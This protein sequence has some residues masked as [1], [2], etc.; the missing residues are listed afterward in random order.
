MVVW[1]LDLD[2]TLYTDRTGL[3]PAISARI[4]R[5]LEV[6]L[7]LAPGA[8]QALRR[9]WVAAY[10]TTLQ[11]LLHEMPHH[12]DPYD[13][14]AFTHDLPLEAYLAPDP[15]LRRTLEALPGPKWV[16]TN[17]DAAHARRVLEILGVAEVFE[18]IIDI[19]ATDLHP[20]PWE[21]AYRQALTL[22]GNPP[23]GD[24]VLVDD[25]LCNLTAARPLGFRTVWVAREAAAAEARQVD[26]VIPEIYALPRAFPRIAGAPMPSAARGH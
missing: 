6:R 14:F 26:A 10:G 23:P 18:G 24:A 15:R 12:A 22:A 16:F 11:G 5:Y 20:K 4:T 19:F 3:W 1:L 25:R 8:A 9:R 13:Y 17:A 7:G 2:G 21:S